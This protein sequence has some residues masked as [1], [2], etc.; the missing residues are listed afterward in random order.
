MV[1][2]QAKR[3][4]K[5]PIKTTGMKGIRKHLTKFAPFADGFHSHCSYTFFSL[6]SHS[7]SEDPHLKYVHWSIVFHPRIK[8]TQAMKR[9]EE[10]GEP[11]N[12][13]NER[14]QEHDIDSANVLQ[15]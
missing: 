13:R 1:I 10:E 11:K 4:R 6:S 14:H 9:K 3:K 2:M 7:P 5:E 8:I 12:H 15:C